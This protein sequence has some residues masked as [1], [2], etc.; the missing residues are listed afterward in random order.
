MFQFSWLFFYFSAKKKKARSHTLQMQQK[1][2]STKN[3]IV[4]ITFNWENC[5]WWTLVIVNTS[6]P[7]YVNFDIYFQ[8]T[9]A[10]FVVVL[11]GFARMEEFQELCKE[12]LSQVRKTHGNQFRRITTM[13][14]P[15][16]AK[17]Q[18]SYCWFLAQIQRSREHFAPWATY[19]L[20]NILSECSQEI[21]R[22][23]LIG[24]V[25]WNHVLFSRLA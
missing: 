2:V 5:Q 11:R 9:D 20:T 21:E 22:K 15:A 6:H 17:W 8:W 13:N 19:S 1:H 3:C 23:W 24:L 4:E 7:G 25:L 14:F 12:L 10:Y 16:C 18:A